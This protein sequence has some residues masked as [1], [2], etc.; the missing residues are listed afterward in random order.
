MNWMILI[1]CSMFFAHFVFSMRYLYNKGLINN[2]QEGEQH[3]E[4]TEFSYFIPDEDRTNCYDKA[5]KCE[6]RYCDCPKL[7]KSNNFELTEIYDYQ[8]VI[9][10][11]QFL[12]PGFY[13]LPKVTNKCKRFVS[14]LVYTGSNWACLCKYP[15]VFAGDNCASL[16]ACL[17]PNVASTNTALWDYKLNER[18]DLHKDNDYYELLPNGKFRFR[19]VCGKDD[20]DNGLILFDDI[21]FNCFVDKCKGNIPRSSVKG[22]DD[23][24]MCCNCGDYNVTRQKN[25]IAN[26]VTSPCT[27]CYNSYSDKR[28]TLSG[29]CYNINSHRFDPE[30][31]FYP[32]VNYFDPV[33]NCYSIDFNVKIM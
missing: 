13:C 31:N 3:I 1:L 11:K 29:L 21:P 5:F 33:S 15:N 8:R 17:M 23:K 27:T 24:L 14:S 30:F 7:C 19:C 16:V 12:Q 32:S 10:K 6:S 9:Y 18:T 26:D 22:F 28:L 4:G 2:I 20:K 25:S